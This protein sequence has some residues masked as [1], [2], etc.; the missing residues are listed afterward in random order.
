MSAF[1]IVPMVIFVEVRRNRSVLRANFNPLRQ[2]CTF[3][4]RRFKSVG[5]EKRKT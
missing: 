3:T 5:E 1:P 4:A 2:P